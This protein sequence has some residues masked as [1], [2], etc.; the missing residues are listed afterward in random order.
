MS[1]PKLVRRTF[2]GVP[3]FLHVDR[4]AASVGAVA[5]GIELSLV[6]LRES[7][8]VGLTARIVDRRANE[9]PWQGALLVAGLPL[10]SPHAKLK[11]GLGVRMAAGPLAFSLLAKSKRPE[12]P[13]ISG[14]RKLYYAAAE[15]GSVDGILWMLAADVVIQRAYATFYRTAPSEQAEDHNEAGCDTAASM[16]AAFIHTLATAGKD[17]EATRAGRG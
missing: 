12:L 13:D 8:N 6:L 15:L 11:P 16:L 10:E 17:R 9:T 2:M 7:W 14:L 5:G 1:A 4:K 3:V